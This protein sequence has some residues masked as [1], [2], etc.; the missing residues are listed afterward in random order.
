MDHDIPPLAVNIDRHFVM[1]QFPKQA[2][3]IP[4]IFRLVDFNKSGDK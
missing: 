3:V 1:R 2:F 4:A